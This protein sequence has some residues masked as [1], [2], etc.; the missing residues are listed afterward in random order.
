MTKFRASE[1]INYGTLVYPITKMNDIWLELKPAKSEVVNG[2]TKISFDIPNLPPL[3]NALNQMHWSRKHSFSEDWLGLISLVTSQCIPKISFRKARLTLIRKS[4]K[5]PDA[6]GLVG[7]FKMIIDALVNLKILEDDSYTHIG[8]PTYSWE[9]TSKE[10][11]RISVIIEE[12][13]T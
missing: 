9:K 6:D 4:P 12:V 8:M 7:S 3:Q 2:L 13:K 1:V 11:Q 10:T 5:V